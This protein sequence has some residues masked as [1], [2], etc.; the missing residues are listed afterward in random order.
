[1]ATNESAALAK[2]REEEEIFRVLERDVAL[3]IV[4][5]LEAVSLARPST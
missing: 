3:Q 5:R 1:M 2:A 4:R